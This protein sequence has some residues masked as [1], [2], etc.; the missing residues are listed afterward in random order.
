MKQTGH[1]PYGDV[2][3]RDARFGLW[4]A[5][6][7]APAMLGSLLLVM[8]ASVAVG[9]WAGLLPLTWAVAAAVLM[10]RVGERMAV[11]VVLGFQRPS[12]TQEAALKPAWS[13]ALRVTRTAAGDAELYVQTARTPNAFAAGGRSVAVT[14]RVLGDYAAGRLPEDQLVAVLVH[15]LGHRATGA[16][17]PMLIVSWLSA[18]WLLARSLLT[19]LASTLAGRRTQ[20]GVVVLVVAGLAVAATRAAQQGQWMVG[21]VLVFVGLATV[22]GLL[23]DAAISRR[24]EYAADRFA[25]DH[26]LAL[27][28]AAALYALKGG[29]REAPRSLRRLWATHPSVDRRIAALLTAK[30]RSDGLETPTNRKERST[31]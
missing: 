10:T 17:R 31:T 7:A 16:T 23:A 3:H 19:G 18:P 2:R 29:G 26:G 6:A 14:S 21:G 30:D 13:M 20:R 15:E 1:R 11:R 24:S 27:E 28:L 25:A 12:P 5:V 8:V 22:L 9:R 4:R